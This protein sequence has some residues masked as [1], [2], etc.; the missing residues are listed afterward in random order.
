MHLEDAIL[1]I[2][3]KRYN[4][5]EIEGHAAQACYSLARA[6]GPFNGVKGDNVG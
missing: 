5:N 6:P 2:A 4:A 1:G 3:R